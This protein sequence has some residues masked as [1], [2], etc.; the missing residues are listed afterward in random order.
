MSKI[1]S[2]ISVFVAAAFLT[3]FGCSGNGQSG[4]V[5]HNTINQLM[6][7][8]NRF[9]D[10]TWD[11]LGI[12]KMDLISG[13]TE[14]YDMAASKSDSDLQLKVLFAMGDSGIVEFYPILLSAIDF[15]PFLVCMALCNMPTGD[16]IPVV[17]PY[18]NDDIIRIRRGAIWALEG[19]PFY[20]EFPHARER[21]LLALCDRLEL[22]QVD[23]LRDEIKGAIAKIESQR[24]SE[25]D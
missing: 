4:M 12:D 21:A 7:L 9:E 5:D 11:D 16:A 2:L 25:P 19:F 14:I 13:L 10:N 6:Q 3:G 24:N 23:W 15:E 1:H 20:S 18:L 8:L 22:E 17:I